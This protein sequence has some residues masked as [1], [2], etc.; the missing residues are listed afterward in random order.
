MPSLSWCNQ[1][2]SLKTIRTKGTMPS[3]LS[4]KSSFLSSKHTALQA[5]CSAQ[6]Q[7]QLLLGSTFSGSN[8]WSLR[9][10]KRSGCWPLVGEHS[11]EALFLKR[12]R[13]PGGVHCVGMCSRPVSERLTSEKLSLKQRASLSVN[14]IK[15]PLNSLVRFVV[16]RHLQSLTDR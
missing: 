12:Q 7:Q 8:I 4:R 14:L 5:W 3:L 9:R 2:T 11:G 6:S 16:Q 15:S 10:T 13:T 1:K